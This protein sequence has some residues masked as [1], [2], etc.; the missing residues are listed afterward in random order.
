MGDTLDLRRTETRRFPE[1]SWSSESNKQ[2]RDSELSFHT[3]M[4]D[5]KKLHMQCTPFLIFLTHAY[6]IKC[7]VAAAVSRNSSILCSLF[8]L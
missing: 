8:M 5:V 4:H 6:P 1:S 2:S 3:F 7:S